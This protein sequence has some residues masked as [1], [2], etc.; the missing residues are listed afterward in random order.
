MNF[1]S[2]KDKAR[3]LKTDIYALYLA[4]KDRRTPWY[5][6]AFIITVVA[7]TLNPID[8]IPDFIPV[9]GYIDDLI[10]I[11][12]GIYLAIKMIPRTVMNECRQRAR[13]EKIDS[14]T[15]WI[16]AGVIILV[17]LVIIFWIIKIFWL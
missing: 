11:P 12:A 16:A 8:L 3:R 14:K 4:F 2:W 10:I 15:K 17:W 5:A 7:F 13:A 1:K 6:R 9:L